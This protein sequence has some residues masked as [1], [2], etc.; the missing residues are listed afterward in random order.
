MTA[1][2]R[3]LGWVVESTELSMCPVNNYSPLSVFIVRHD[4]YDFE[5]TDLKLLNTITFEQI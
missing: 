1:S 2:N 5:V 4:H 3:I